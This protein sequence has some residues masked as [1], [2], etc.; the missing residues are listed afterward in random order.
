VLFNSGVF[1]V[2]LGVV[3]ALYY[4]IR[5]YRWQNVML[6]AASYVFYGAWDVRFLPL[7]IGSTFVDYWAARGIQSTSKPAL[8]R[9]WLV[10]A[11]SLN[12]AV[13]GFFKYLDFGMESVTALLGWLGMRADLPTLHIILPVGISFYTLQS[14]QI[15]RA[16]SPTN[17]PRRSPP[18]LGHRRSRAARRRQSCTKRS[19]TLL[20]VA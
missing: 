8:R 4:A 2:F 6:L 14:G 19:T 16:R 18:A 15:W 20:G 5:H 3:L 11:V 12:L 1:V 10:M 9:L 13:L 17:L 7:M